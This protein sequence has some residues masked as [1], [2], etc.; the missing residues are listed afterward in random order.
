MNF[1]RLEYAY[2]SIIIHVFISS[3]SYAKHMHESPAC[4]GAV[5]TVEFSRSI[6]NSWD[7]IYVQNLLDSFAM[8]AQLE[9]YV[10]PDRDCLRVFGDCP[11]SKVFLETHQH[12]V[13]RL[14]M[15][16]QY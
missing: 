3:R 2:Y 9:E 6:L 1:A 16:K 7:I 14:Y 4:T 11:T 10:L 15:F 5:N 13:Q 8:H 12:I